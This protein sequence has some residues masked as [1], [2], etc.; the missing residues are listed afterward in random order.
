MCI[1]EGNE[2]LLS[3]L[4]G[5]KKKKLDQITFNLFHIPSS[6]QIYGA[7]NLSIS[8]YLELFTRVNK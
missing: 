3:I 8:I 2:N 7:K 1:L 6:L 4:A 5:R